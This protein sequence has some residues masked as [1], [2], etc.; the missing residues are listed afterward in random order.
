MCWS[1]FWN[2][3]LEFVLVT[4]KRALRRSLAIERYETE[5]DSQRRTSGGRWRGS[6][7]RA[8]E[9]GKI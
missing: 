9:L 1:N 4:L 8:R 5:S 3:F 7:D 2:I 6:D